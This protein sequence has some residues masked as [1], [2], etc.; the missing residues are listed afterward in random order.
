LEILQ[1]LIGALKGRLSY[2]EIT[3]PIIY[4]APKEVSAITDLSSDSNIK[5]AQEYPW[6]KVVCATP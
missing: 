3:I 5:I 4:M 1:S 6:L 2:L